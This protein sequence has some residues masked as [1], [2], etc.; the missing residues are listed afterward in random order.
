MAGLSMPRKPST[1]ASKGES[2]ADQPELVSDDVADQIARVTA[3][4]ERGPGDDAGRQ[5]LAD[6]Y[7]HA[8]HPEH[9]EPVV[10]VPGQALPAWVVEEL[11]AGRFTRD[12]DGV[13][14]SPKSGGGS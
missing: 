9:G 1:A 6:D 3:G 5:V 11:N 7:V 10:Y 13:T 14:L 2:V 4:Q 8:V 12:R